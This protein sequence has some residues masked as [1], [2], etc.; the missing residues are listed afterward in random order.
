MIFLQ[1]R[2]AGTENMSVLNIN[3]L[4]ILN[5]ILRSTNVSPKIHPKICEISKKRLHRKTHESWQYYARYYICYL[6]VFFMNPRA[7]V[8]LLISI[9]VE[10]PDFWLRKQINSNG[11]AWHGNVDFDWYFNSILST[12]YL[13]RSPPPNAVEKKT[14]IEHALW[15]Y[16]VETILKSCDLILLSKI[17]ASLYEV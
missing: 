5:G 16:W 8:M 7:L 9:E 6:L 11:M 3:S 2:S 12:T 4:S 17:S 10:I 13:F 1:K 14:T 15:I